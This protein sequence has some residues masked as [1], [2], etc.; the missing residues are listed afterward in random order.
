M[1]DVLCLTGGKIK[2]SSVVKLVTTRPAIIVYW[3]EQFFIFH[4]TLSIPTPQLALSYTM[5]AWRHFSP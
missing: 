5:F 4:T 1:K 3:Q 2:D